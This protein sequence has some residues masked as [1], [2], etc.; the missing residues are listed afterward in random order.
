MKLKKDEKLQKDFFMNEFLSDSDRVAPTP[1]MLINLTKLSFHAQALR[2]IVGRMRVTS[3]G[4][5]YSYNVTVG[6]TN[7]SYHIKGMAMDFELINDNGV[8]D[9]GDWTVKTL[10]AIA[11]VCGFSNIGFYLRKGKFQ[12]IHVDIGVTWGNYKNWKKYSDTLSY[13][14]VE[15]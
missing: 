7:N 8:E 6:G 5:S 12:W 11:N 2:N 13:Q 4:R 3:G 14:I 10:L 9:Y 1:E 15:V